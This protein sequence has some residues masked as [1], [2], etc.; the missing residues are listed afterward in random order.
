MILN[1]SRRIAR[2]WITS[3]ETRLLKFDLSLVLLIDCSAARE[4]KL[5]PFFPRWSHLVEVQSSNSCHCC[6]LRRSNQSARLSSPSAVRRSHLSSQCDHCSTRSE[7]KPSE[8]NHH[9]EELASKNIFETISD[10]DRTSTLVPPTPMITRDLLHE[11]EF[12]LIDEHERLQLT[13]A[14][15]EPAAKLA[16][17]VN[18]SDQ[19]IDL[20]YDTGALTAE[21]KQ[22]IVR[23]TIDKLQLVLNNRPTAT[24]MI[25]DH[26]L[27]K[28]ELTY[29]ALQSTIDILTRSVNWTTSTKISGRK[30]KQGDPSTIVTRNLIPNYFWINPISTWDT[31]EKFPHVKIYFKAAE[32]LEKNRNAKSQR[33]LH[34]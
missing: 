1:C 28:I 34:D 5:W 2:R 17:K 4:E 25:L 26:D 15:Y 13:S 30:R 18:T 3:R 24:T 10:L 29:R 12:S 19:A 8:T 14:N 23:Q 32:E 20:F 11:L 31:V 21:D 22:S 16:W 9:D 6:S 33:I 27:D 7:D